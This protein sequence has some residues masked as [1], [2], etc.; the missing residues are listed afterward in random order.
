MLLP[1]MLLLLFLLLLQLL[2]MLLLLLLLLPLMLSLLL[3]GS[4]SISYTDWLAWQACVQPLNEYQEATVFATEFLLVLSWHWFCLLTRKIIIQRQY[5]VKIARTVSSSRSPTLS[6]SLE[7]C[8]R[9]Q[10]LMLVVIASLVGIPFYS[11]YRRKS[12]CFVLN[13]FHLLI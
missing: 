2:P 4:Q 1:P 10:Y 12:C 8:S 9:L 3:P 11:R 7:A 5:A 13:I 6:S